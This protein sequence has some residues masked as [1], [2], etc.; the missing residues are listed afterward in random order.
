MFYTDFFRSV[1][2]K[3]SKE[4]HR[5]R[6]IVFFKIFLSFF[7]LENPEINQL[8][9]LPSIR[10]LWIFRWLHDGQVTKE[11]Q[12]TSSPHW[13]PLA[14]RARLWTVRK[15]ELLHRWEAARRQDASICTQNRTKS[16]CEGTETLLQS[17]QPD[18]EACFDLPDF[19][20][21]TWIES[22]EGNSWNKPSCS[23]IWTYVSLHW[24]GLV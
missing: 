21:C 19:L 14:S 1:V 17:L 12:T 10:S 15:P 18:Y 20:F 9:K 2:E 16:N 24:P 3:S 5:K 11:T 23:W 22:L 7:S 13:Q 6:M 8:T 4:P